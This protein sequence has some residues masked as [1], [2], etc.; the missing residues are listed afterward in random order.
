MEVL[1][2]M[3]EQHAKVY[4]QLDGV[5]RELEQGNRKL[6]QDNRAA[7]QRIQRWADEGQGS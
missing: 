5:A 7:Q 1:R 3:N 2:T 4:E 6:T